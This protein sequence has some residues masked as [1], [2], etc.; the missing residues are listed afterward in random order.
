MVWIGN[1]KTESVP[2]MKVL[3]AGRSSNTTTI[4]EENLREFCASYFPPAM[5]REY[6]KTY[7]VNDVADMADLSVRFMGVGNDRLR[8]T[9]E[10]SK[11]LTPCK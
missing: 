7:R 3:M 2:L 6:R 10:R 5:P 9:L 11:G 4:Y 8:Q 1:K